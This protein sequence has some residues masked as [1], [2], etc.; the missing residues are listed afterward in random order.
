MVE[1]TGTVSLFEGLDHI[2]I[3]VPRSEEEAAR[4]FYGQVLGLS[5]IPKPAVL[6]ERGGAWY[7]CGD[8][9]LHLGIDE[10]HTPQAKAHPAF[11]VSDLEALRQRLEKAARPIIDDV[12]IPGLPTL[13]DPRSIRQSAGIPAGAGIWRRHRRSPGFTRERSGER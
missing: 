13:F 7:R 4:A 6:R 8:Q 1:T 2:Q 11:R 10:D 9:Q 5:E 3:T 12:E